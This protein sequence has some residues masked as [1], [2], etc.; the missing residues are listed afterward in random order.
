MYNT[1][2]K[3]RL[4]LFKNKVIEYGRNWIDYNQR[5]LNGVRS[6]QQIV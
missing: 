1:M 5:E 3:P 2:I 6:I 4:E